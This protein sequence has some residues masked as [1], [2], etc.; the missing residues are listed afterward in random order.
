MNYSLLRSK[1]FWT[2]VVMFLY[3]GYA[4]ISGQLPGDV[5]VIVNIIFTALGSYFHLQTGQS[6]A[7]TN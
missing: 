6:T 3:N 2:L 5:T 4:A 7:G 1:T